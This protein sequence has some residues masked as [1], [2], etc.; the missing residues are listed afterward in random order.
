MNCI[1]RY[2]EAAVGESSEPS[3][4]LLHV[5]RPT[6]VHTTFAMWCSHVVPVLQRLHAPS[7]LPS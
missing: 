6:D 2:D 3:D 1:K 4:K 7:D 5:V